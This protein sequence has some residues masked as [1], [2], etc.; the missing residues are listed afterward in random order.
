MVQ[1]SFTL[2]YLTGNS[3]QEYIYIYIYIYIYV[4][5]KIK[6]VCVDICLNSYA[7]ECANTESL[8]YPTISPLTCRRSSTRLV[9]VD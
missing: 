2:L 5:L 6:S 1:E 3:F 4:G 7:Q 9:T 8:F